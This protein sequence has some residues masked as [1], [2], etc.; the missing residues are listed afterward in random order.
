MEDFLSSAAE[1]GPIVLL[2]NTDEERVA[3]LFALK[4]EGKL[5]GM[6]SRYADRISAPMS[7][8]P[9]K[10]AHLT[11]KFVLLLILFSF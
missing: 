9:E 6:W 1:K 7:P 10:T 11:G 2:G 8:P 4:E 5:E 3:S